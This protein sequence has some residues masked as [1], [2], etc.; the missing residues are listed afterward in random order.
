MKGFAAQGRAGEGIVHRRLR[1]T[2][3]AQGMCG[4]RPGSL[5]IVPMCVFTILGA[6]GGQA[7]RWDTVLFYRES[8]SARAPAARA[9]GLLRQLA[10]RHG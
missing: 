4:V 5:V 10:T 3:R 9:Q 8:P 2:D 1:H 7:G 6:G